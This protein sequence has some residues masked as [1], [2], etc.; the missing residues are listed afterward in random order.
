M[1]IEDQTL[2]RGVRFDVV[3]LTHLGSDGQP[4]AR[5]VVRHPGAVVVLPLVTPERVCLIRNVRVAVGKTLL[6]LPN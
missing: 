4:H 5:Q 1:K 6:E 3:E 2:F